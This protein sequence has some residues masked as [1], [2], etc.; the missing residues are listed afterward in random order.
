M[1]NNSTVC[2]TRAIGLTEKPVAK[3]CEFI[4]VVLALRTANSH[5]AGVIMMRSFV[6]N[7]VLPASSFPHFALSSLRLPPI[8]CG[9]R[10]CP[11]CR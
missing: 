4:F 3:H 7:A 1:G 6:F 11:L 8:A 5:A 10:G 9:T 2:S